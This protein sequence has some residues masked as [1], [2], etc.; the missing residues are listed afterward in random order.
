MT[1]RFITAW[2]GYHADQIVSGLGD[3]EEERLVGLGYA[4]TDLDGPGNTPTIIKAT[5]DPVSG[6]IT[7]N[8]SID[9]DVRAYGV[10]ADGTIIPGCNITG[11][12]N[13]GT[14]TCT[15]DTFVSSDVGK[16]I[17]FHQAFAAGMAGYAM[18]TGV[19]TAV[20]GPRNF[21][22]GVSSCPTLTSANAIFGT[23]N[24]EALNA[25]INALALSSFGGTLQFPVGTV[26]AY[27]FR[28]ARANSTEYTVDTIRTR[29]TSNGYVYKCI[30]A[31]TSGVSEP[32]YVDTYGSTFTDGSVV[33]QCIGRTT[34][35]IPSG[36]VVR[37]RG[38]GL[39]SPYGYVQT[40]SVILGI[41]YDAS[42]NLCILNKSSQMHDIVVDC[43]TNN[44]SA[45]EVSSLLNGKGNTLINVGAM[46]GTSSAFK[47]GDGTTETIGCHFMGRLQSGAY[48]LDTVGDATHIGGVCAGAGNGAATIRVRNAVDDTK[49]EGVH[50][51]KGG[52]GLTLSTVSG[53]NIRWENVTANGATGGGNIVG[54][55]FDT[56]LGEHIELYVSG[57]TA[58]R[59]EALTIANNQF[60]QPQEAFTT[61]TYSVIKIEATASAPAVSYSALSITGNVAKGTPAGNQY[62]SFINYAL[63]AGTQVVADVVIGNTI[64]GAAALYTGTAH[65]QSYTA[66]NAWRTTAGVT[67]VG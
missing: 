29:N 22:I 55:T 16:R 19:I 28:T 66:G 47:N 20:A 11:S 26:M 25:A 30:T 38:R 10:V 7:V 48:A 58:S 54:N 13:V 18:Y 31:G 40:G 65:T 56:C 59:I 4:V 67:T 46:G 63:N 17:C 53:P 1:I 5:V 61:N 34:L 62:A 42:Y 50:I 3:T 8:G 15:S 43:G 32:T 52:W 9:V 23:D 44:A 37:G 60:Y 36:S 33:W 21:T 49:I 27:P 14:C 39:L 6:V 12:G 57:G 64:Q 51:Y 45:I 2:S 24:S 41:G 35:V